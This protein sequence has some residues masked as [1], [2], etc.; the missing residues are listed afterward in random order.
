MYDDHDDDNDGGGGVDVFFTL[1][2]S[3]ILTSV[4]R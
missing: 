3:P 2:T 4:G 1:R